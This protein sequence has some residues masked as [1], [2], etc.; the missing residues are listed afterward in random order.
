MQLAEG[1]KREDL[2][3][4][5]KHIFEVDAYKS[6]MGDDENVVVLSFE[7]TGKQPALDLV[8]FVEKSYDFIL[9]ADTS[10]GEDDNGNYK[11]F[12]EIERNRKISRQISEMMY[13]LSE[14]TGCEDWKF[15]YYKDYHSKPLHE[16]GSIPSSADDYKATM[17]GIFE[18]EMR[19][20]FRRSR[21]DYLIAEENI[22]TF[23]RPFANPVKM[24]MLEY[25]TRTDILNNLAGNIRVEIGRAHV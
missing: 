1:L 22:I 20:F 9:D 23:K 25:G 14:L 8:D 15:R 3:D 7:V 5:I 6:K 10:N 18:S 13:G 2:K 16:I 24:K 4:L 12:V 17:E 11:V 21:F 19:H